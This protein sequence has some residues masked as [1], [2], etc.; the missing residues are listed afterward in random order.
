MKQNKAVYWLQLET[1][2]ET[3]FYKQ[4]KTDCLYERKAKH[5]E[6]FM[7]VAN[8]MAFNINFFTRVST[9]VMSRAPHSILRK[10]Y[11]R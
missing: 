2:D 4:F 3:F 10:S 8:V 7:N 1:I 5:N 11:L 6:L 9:H